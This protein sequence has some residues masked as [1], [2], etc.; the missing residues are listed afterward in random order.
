VSQ[1]LLVL[2]YGDASPAVLQAAVAESAD[3]EPSVYL[4]AASRVGPLDWLATDEGRARDE[5]AARVLEAEWLLAGQAELGGGAGDVDPVLAVRDALEHFAADEILVVG[6]GRIDYALLT[7]LEALGPPLR[8]H[9][10]T[11]AAPARGD[12]LRAL[13]RSLLGGRSAATPLVA[14]IAWNV[15]LLIVILVCSGVALLVLWLLGAL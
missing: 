3:P 14:L 15:G 9:G 5:A 7:A 2:L 6:S 13:A 8:L 1:R 10:V 12:R 4:V 11:V